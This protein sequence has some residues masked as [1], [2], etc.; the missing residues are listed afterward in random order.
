MSEE[1][2]V[3]IRGKKYQTVAYRVGKF[4]EIHPD[5]GIQTELSLDDGNRVIM[6]A[7]ITNTD[8]MIV[9]TGFAEEVRGSS[10]IN[11]TSALEN[12]ETS[13]IGRA[14]SA[15]GMGGTSYA[16]ADE[17]ANAVSQQNEKALYD[18]FKVFTGALVDNFRSVDAVKLGIMDAQPTETVKNQFEFA[19]EPDLSTAIEAWNE[20]DTDTKTA[21]WLA[22]TKG[23]CFTTVERAIMKSDR[24]AALSREMKVGDK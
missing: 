20:L 16:S 7:V 18:R 5:Y 3:D 4:R 24:W 17:V 15:L 12:C 23:G 22:P 10:N 19:S 8:G 11:Q 9:A 1:G 2:I 21:L 6:K 14:L 13:A